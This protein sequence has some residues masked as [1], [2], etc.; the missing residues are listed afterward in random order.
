MLKFYQPV[1]IVRLAVICMVLMSFISCDKNAANPTSTG[2]RDPLKQPFHQKSIWNM[3]IGSKA[4]YVPAKILLSAQNWLTADEDVIIL[5]SDAPLTNIRYNSAGWDRSKNRCTPEGPAIY[6]APIPEDFIY[7]PDT[8][9]GL[10]PN[11]S[12]AIL[13]PDGK[14]L[15][16]FQP[17]ARCTAKE[18]ATGQYKYPTVDINGEGIEGAHGGSGLSSIGGTIRLGE[19]VPGG[20]IPHAMKMN[21]YAKK[22]YYFRDSEPD[23]KAGFR[24]PA[25]KADGYANS[26]SYAGKN[27]ALQ[28]GSL[29]ALKP[30]FDLSQLETEA[31]QILAQAFLNYGAYIVD[32]TAWDVYALC[33]EHSPNGKM[34]DEFEQM[35]GFEFEGNG[36]S[37]GWK[38]DYKKIMESLHVIDNNSPDS[39]GGGGNPLVPLA[40]PLKR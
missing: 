5:T 16:Q 30:D 40:A 20:K 38:R 19:L 36:T 37:N 29:L 3:P 11:A 12:T 31:A 13:M 39:V 1:K 6:L 22:N 14:T 34:I 15:I 24:W 25:V 28:I 23:G 26:E 35:W 9:E 18:D 32:D 21:L 17:F 4:E 7:S 10:T 27:P 8:W 2:T 33:T